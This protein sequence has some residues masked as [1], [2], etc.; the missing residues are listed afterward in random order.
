[1]KISNKPEIQQTTFN[2]SSDIDFMNLCEKCTAKPYSPLANDATLA[3][4]NPSYFTKNLLDWIWQ[5]IITID[6][7]IRD[8]TLEYDINRKAEWISFRRRNITT[9]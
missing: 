7:K 2:H 9:S 8:E 5:L 4:G 6:D 3:S 1:M